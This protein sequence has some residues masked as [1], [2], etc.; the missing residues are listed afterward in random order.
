MAHTPSPHRHNYQDTGIPA[1]DSAVAP[2]IDTE[3]HATAWIYTMAFSLAIC[4]G[5]PEDILANL[6]RVLQSD[7]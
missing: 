6:P 1:N 3:C 7:T 2:F 5:M 4:S